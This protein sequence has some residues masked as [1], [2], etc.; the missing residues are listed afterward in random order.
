MPK[1]PPAL[2]VA[3]VEKTATAFIKIPGRANFTSSV[4]FKT[5]VAELR[6]RGI[7]HLVLDL[8]E[9]ITMD[10][11]F[12]GVLASLAL[13]SEDGKDEFGRKIELELL[14]PNARICDLLEN[15]GVVHFFNI[16]Q[17]AMP[18]TAVFEPVP[19][20]K[21]A[22]EKDEFTKTCL[23]AHQALMDINPENI[24]KFKDVARFLAEDLKKKP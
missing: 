3:L 12:L 14:N 2:S 21:P 11:T 6:G 10:S 17:Q 19:S 4:D 15:L 1:A 22:P 24:P 7:D 5:V 20:N 8:G 9:C 13:K 18:A 16:T 23:E